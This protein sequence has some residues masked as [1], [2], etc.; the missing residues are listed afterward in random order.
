MEPKTPHYQLAGRT[1]VLT[2]STD[3]LGEALARA[4]RDL[5]ARLALLD[6]DGQ[7]AFEQ[8]TRLGSEATARAWQADVRD[9]GSLTAAFDA[10]ASHFGRVDVAIANASIDSF[11]PLELIEPALYE[12]MIDVNLNGVW[13]T[14]RAAL[15]HV[16]KQHGY[17]LATSSMAGNVHSPVQIPY[18]ASKA[19]VWAMCNT[20]RLEVRRLGVDVGSVHPAL[21]T[22]PK[23]DKPRSDIADDACW[24]SGAMTHRRT[25]PLD[26]VV[27]SIITGIAGRAPRIVAPRDTAPPA[28][29]ELVR[30][31]VGRNDRPDN[32][33]PPVIDSGDLTNGAAYEPDSSAAACP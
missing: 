6:P 32:S 3:D 15:P 10:A 24:T 26:A 28:K 1:V 9:L 11:A 33:L 22:P 23:T 25:T 16:G 12:R 19:A 7:A 14:F 27:Q 17:L 4:L 18:G 8:A 13:R 29:P 20:L 31:Y 30:P 2:G 5:G 21:F